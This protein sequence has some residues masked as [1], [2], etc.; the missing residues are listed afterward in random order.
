LQDQQQVHSIVGRLAA[1]TIAA[2]GGGDAVQA[3]AAEL[4]A[5]LPLPWDAKITA[6]ARGMQITGI[7]LCVTNGRD[8]ITCYCFTDLALAEAK[9]AVKN[10]LTAALND[11]TALV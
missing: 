3:F 11:W 8:L 4:A 6:T 10:L 1:G 5:S 2:L 9:A 7:L